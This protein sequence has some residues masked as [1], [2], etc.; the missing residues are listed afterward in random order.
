[1]KRT[2]FFKNIFLVGLLLFSLVWTS[3]SDD[4][5]EYTPIALSSITTIKDQNTPITEASMGDYIAIHGT[6]LSIE[7]IDSILVND[8]KVNML[9][10][11]TEKSIL[12]MPI[13][14]K[15]TTNETDK[16][17]IYNKLGTQEL[18]LKVYPPDL[19]LDRMFNEYTRPGDTI[20]IY[21]NYFA[22][23]EIDSVNAVVD[24]NG[25]TS[26]VIAFGDKYL[27]ARV[28]Q[29]V[30]KDIKVKVKSLKYDA[31]ATCPGRYYDR[32]F[33]IM[34]YD[35]QIG[36]LEDASYVVTNVADKQRLSG[37]FMRIDETS[38]WSGWWY[39]TA[40]GG[41]EYTSDMLTNPG[42]YV[43]KMEFRTSNQLIQ[44]KIAFYTYLYWNAPPLEWT[45][46]DF[47]FQNPN[48]WETITLPFKNFVKNP[49]YTDDSYYRSFNLRLAIDASIA[50]NFAIDNIRIYKKGN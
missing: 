46:T 35:D 1:M 40:R 38:A 47:V 5:Y 19:Y 25:K 20:M 22:L 11:Y 8:V 16:I 50:R 7:N 41:V 32:E 39:I 15:L 3:C 28:P 18:P 30:D 13:P 36:L 4:D 42:N 29:N 44:D 33:M 27:T 43:V 17:Y 49:D 24:F 45:A 23:Y 6:G 14:V 10:I 31:E 9:D 34:D 26:K 21:G 2:D 48:R 37:N 12:Y